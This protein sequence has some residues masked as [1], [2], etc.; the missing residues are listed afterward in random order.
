MFKVMRGDKVVGITAS[1][2]SAARIARKRDSEYG[3]SVHV[4]RD[5]DGRIRF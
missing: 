1:L 5:V 2:K 3:A 4:I